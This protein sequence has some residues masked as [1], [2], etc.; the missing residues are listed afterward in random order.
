MPQRPQRC[1]GARPWRWCWSRT[2]GQRLLRQF[3]YVCTR[4]SKAV[5]CVPF[6]WQRGHGAVVG[7]GACVTHAG[8]ASIGRHFLRIQVEYAA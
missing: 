2:I 8:H 5:K 7:E 6:V 3:L 4:T 1:F